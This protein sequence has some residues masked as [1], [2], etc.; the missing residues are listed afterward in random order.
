MGLVPTLNWLTSKLAKE[1]GMATEIQISGK[2]NHLPP[3][4][5][6]G[7]FRIVQEGLKNIYK[8]AGAS[9][10]GV[11]V[12]FD[13][14]KVKIAIID[15]GKGFKVPSILTDFLENGKLGLVGIFDRVRGLNGSLK[16]ES[17]PEKGTRIVIEIPC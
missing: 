11:S 13:E 2:A 14:H 1:N 3:D 12:E 7:I 8:H 9:L 6:L 4:M 17:S 5:E 15:N 10:A 16:I